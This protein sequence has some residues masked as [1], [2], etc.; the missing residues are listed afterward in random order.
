M[1]VRRSESRFE[2]KPN[3]SEGVF[4][5]VTPGIRPFIPSDGN[6]GAGLKWLLKQGKF[7]DQTT[8]HGTVFSAAQQWH[9]VIVGLI[10]QLFGKDRPNFIGLGRDGETGLAGGALNLVPTP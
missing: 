2:H 4:F 3:G 5:K 1:W 8:M 7:I 6:S 10:A 9:V